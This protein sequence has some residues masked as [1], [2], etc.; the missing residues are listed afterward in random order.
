MFDMM[1]TTQKDLE[2]LYSKYQ[3]I[4]TIK[5]EFINANFP[6]AFE[7]LDLAVGFGLDLLT[8]MH[9]HKRAS[10]GT[11]VGILK[12]HFEHQEK[13]A[14]ACA[15]AILVAAENDLVDWDDIGQVLVVIFEMS[16]D[17]EKKLAEY[18]YPLPM[19]E[20]PKIVRNNRQTG[21]QTIHGSLI[22]KDNHHDDD[23]CLD[24]I[25]RVNA[26]PLSLNMDVVAFVQNQ[27]KNLDKP[28]EHES[29]QEYRERKKAFEKYDESSRD[30][31]AA[32]MAQGNELYLTHKY[33]KRGRTYAQGYHVQYQG[34]DWNKSCIQFAH[35]EK[36]IEE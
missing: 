35:A 28:K 34:N 5:R 18:Q 24:H 27:W 23:I 10:I 3:L 29:Y 15:D 7:E 26:V 19:I 17:I 36:L 11:M 6:A 2:L 8:Q 33:D 1:Q 14:Q 30:V 31:I 22:L 9:L 21:Y 4:P 32:L 20:A 16:E 13:P 12:H 25:N